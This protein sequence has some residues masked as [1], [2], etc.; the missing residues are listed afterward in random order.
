MKMEKS[1]IAVIGAGAIGGITAA[2]MAE[3]GYDVW[4]VCKHMEIADLANGRGLHVRGYCGEH[5]V[6]V[7]SVAAVEELKDSFDLCMI[8]TKAYDMPECAKAMLPLLRE[9]SLVVSMQNGICTDA[10]AAIVGKERTVGC[11]IGW[12]ATMHGPGELEMTSG[13]DFIIG[14]L[15]KGEHPRME[16]LR[17]ALSAVVE[18]RVSQDIYAELYSKLI[19]N[20]CITSL[21]AICGL[22]LGQMLRRSQARRIF[23]GIIREAMN[24][25]HAQ[26]LKVPPFGGRLDYDKLLAGDGALDNL[27]RHAMILLVGLKYR[28]LKSSSLQSLERGRPTEIDY[29][30]GFIAQKGEEL[31][32]DC[33]INR[34]L[35]VMIKEIEGDK[36]SIKVA[37]LYDPVFCAQKS[38]R[39]S[40]KA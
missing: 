3:K 33:P 25:A 21:G 9:D 19:V 18:T 6:P 22:Y 32:V 28:R 40:A 12:G 17:Q 5:T 16:A 7:H 11:V 34:R 4:L 10:L 24:V 20:S 36:R 1:R 2:L 26:G 30:N 31:G 27:R 35:T 39:H 29:F 15:V 8:A 14:R 38:A 13:G 23:L 37:N